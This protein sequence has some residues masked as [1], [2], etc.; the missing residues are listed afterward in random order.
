MWASLGSLLEMDLDLLA[1]VMLKRSQTAA[2]TAAAEAGRKIVEVEDAIH[3]RRSWVV[4]LSMVVMVAK[5]IDGEVSSTL[6]CR[7]FAISPPPLPSAEV[8]TSKAL[9]S[10]TRLGMDTRIRWRLYLVAPPG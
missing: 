2:I 1:V 8:H 9:T 3:I 6:E 5:A 7:A 10:V 4:M